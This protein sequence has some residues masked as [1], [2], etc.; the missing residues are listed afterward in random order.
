MGNLHAGHARLIET[1]RGECDVVA[2]SIFVNPIQFDRLEDYERYGRTVKADVALCSRSGADLIFVPAVEEMYP[3]P[4]Q[5]SVDV[6]GVT[7][8]FCGGSRP[9]HFRGVTT[10]VTKLF[11]IIQPQLAFFG[12]KDAQQLAA[13]QRMVDDL[14]FP[15]RI[16]P[17]ETVREQDGLAMS[18]RNTR[19][20]PEERQLAVCLYRALQRVRELIESGVRDLSSILARPLAL[21]DQPGIRIDYF[22]LADPVTMSPV[23]RI[24]GPA[25]AMGAIW[26]G[27]TRLIDNI[28]CIPR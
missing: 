7:D 20:N 27:E 10:V 24:D 22:G 1:A 4:N 5:T 11:H 26:I 8:Y 17:V 12:Q 6:Q 16:V 13:I 19:L 14:N 18:S 9:G 23:G 2:V 25:L 28:M 3:K 15:V 21:L